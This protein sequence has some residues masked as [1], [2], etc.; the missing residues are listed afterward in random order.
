MITNCNSTFNDTTYTSD[1]SNYPFELS[2][3]QKWAI[4]GPPKREKAAS[5]RYI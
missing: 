1:F 2:D 3:F 5:L 4:K